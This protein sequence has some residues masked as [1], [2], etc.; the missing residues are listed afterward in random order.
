MPKCRELSKEERLKIHFL[1]EE[2]KNKSEIARIMKSPHSTVRY[3]LNRYNITK[4]HENMNRSGRKTVTSAREDRQ[5][6][7]TSLKNRKKTSSELAAELSEALGKK[8]SARTARRRLQNA[9]LKG[10]KARKKPWFSGKNKKTRMQ[11]RLEPQHYTEEDL[12]NIVWSDESN[13]EVCYFN[14]LTFI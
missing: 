7:R 8:I 6:I 3:T 12:S 11:W 14:N 2:G 1:Y 10:C 13:F 5:L 4:S 9:G